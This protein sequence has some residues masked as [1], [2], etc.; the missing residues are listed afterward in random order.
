ML[1]LAGFCSLLIVG[2][3]LAGHRQHMWIMNLVYPITAL[4][5]GP[6]AL[7]FYVTHGRLHS[8]KIMRREQ[9]R[10][11]Q[12]RGMADMHSPG[13]APRHVLKADTHC[14]AGCTLGDIGGEWLVWGLG[15]SFFPKILGHPFGTELLLDF[16]LAWTLGILFQYFSIVPMSNVGKLAGVWH[17]IRADTLSIVAF[18][19]GLFGW[20]AIYELVIWPHHSIH[21]NSPDFWFQ[22]QIGMIIGFFTAYPVNRWL[23]KKGFK[24]K[25]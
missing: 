4:Y 12:A 15:L 13:I 7:W 23:L 18:Q 6:V 8:K 24:E 16:V 17:A 22:M 19:L 25:M 14:G 3:M 1:G 10:L 20:M 11:G 2:D 5:W 9:E 21:I